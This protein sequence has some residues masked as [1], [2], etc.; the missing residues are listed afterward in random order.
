MC[1]SGG[2]VEK[3]RTGTSHESFLL[4]ANSQTDMEEWIRA[5]RRAIWAPL[6]GGKPPQTPQLLLYTQILWLWFTIWQILYFS[7]NV[8]LWSFYYFHS[9]W[10]RSTS[11]IVNSLFMSL[12][13]GCS[14]FWAAP[15][16]DHAVR[17]PVWLS[18]SG[19]CACGEVCLF[20]TWTWAQRGGSLQGP[21]PDQPCPRAAGCIWPWWEAS[22]WQVMHHEEGIFLAAW[23]DT[24]LCS[25]DSCSHSCSSTDVHTVAS[26]LKLYIRELP[27]PIVP[28][29]KY[30]QFLSCAQILPKDTEMV[31]LFCLTNGLY[32]AL[33]VD[34]SNKHVPIYSRAQ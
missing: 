11:K 17:G 32:D 26:L 29:S 7:C 34:P 13:C 23:L 9:E 5:I 12:L 22:V 18:A 1:V 31:T 6:G 27:E 33:K 3:D 30:T 20:H 2:A 8:N 15:G 16:G 28:F 10:Q 19:P 21:W 24:S 25:N 14:H 4:M